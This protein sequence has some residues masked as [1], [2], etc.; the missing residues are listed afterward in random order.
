MRGRAEHDFSFHYVAKK[1]G[2]NKNCEKGETD[3]PNKIIFIS[4]KDHQTFS[5]Y[6]ESCFFSATS[7]L[8]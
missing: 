7:I 6:N 1:K 4:K 2:Y 5:L 8:I 3:I